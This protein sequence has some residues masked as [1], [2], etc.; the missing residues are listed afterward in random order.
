[1]YCY[2]NIQHL[3]VM[4]NNAVGVSLVENTMVDGI[5][6][7]ADSRNQRESA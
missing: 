6:G 7:Q 5:L 1:M 4:M 2:Y 3:L